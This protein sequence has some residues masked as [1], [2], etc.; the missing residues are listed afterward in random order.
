MASRVAGR[1]IQPWRTAAMAV[2]MGGGGRVV[3]ARDG[4]GTPEVVPQR[5][6]RRACLYA[7]ARVCGGGPNARATKTAT[8]S[9]PGTPKEGSPRLTCAPNVAT[10]PSR[11]QGPRLRTRNESQVP[12]PPLTSADLVRPAA[13]TV[14]TTAHA[15]CQPEPPPYTDT[16]TKHRGLSRT[17]R[18]GRVSVS[19]RESGY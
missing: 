1:T 9:S 16:A 13:T 18:T 7:R 12:V 19:E 4:G 2:D 8:A 14:R 10:S 6:R 3:G 5:T 17:P 11:V 15:G